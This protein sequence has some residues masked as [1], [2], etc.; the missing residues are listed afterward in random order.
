MIKAEKEGKGCFKAPVGYEHYKYIVNEVLRLCGSEMGAV[1]VHYSSLNGQEL[2]HLASWKAPFYDPAN[3]KLVDQICLNFIKDKAQQALNPDLRETIGELTAC[4]DV[5]SQQLKIFLGYKI[6][7]T[8]GCLCA[9]FHKN[10]DIAE[11]KQDI[12]GNYAKL[13]NNIENYAILLYNVEELYRCVKGLKGQVDSLADFSN[14][15]GDGY[16]VIDTVNTIKYVGLSKQVLFGY[17]PEEVLGQ[18][19]NTFIK[20]VLANNTALNIAEDTLPLQTKMNF[21]VLAKNGDIM[22]TENIGYPI[23]DNEGRMFQIL[24]TSKVLDKSGGRQV[25]PAE[26]KGDSYPPKERASEQPRKIIAFEEVEVPLGQLSPIPGAIL[27]G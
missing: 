18:K 12:I 1:L 7:K 15:S 4:H 5:N 22:L 25:L 23:Y 27:S 26:L 11:I 17:S 21:H 13:L 19:L 6:N 8:S 9:F 14:S 20:K 2:V 24:I 16:F 10:K 3:N